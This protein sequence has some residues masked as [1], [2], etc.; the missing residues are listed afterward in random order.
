MTATILLSR[1]GAESRGARLE[2]GVL[3]DYRRSA[4]DAPSQ[5]GAVYAA[6]VRRMMPGFDAA[7]VELP[8]SDAWLDF[9]RRRE[10]KPAE[11]AAIVV[12]VVQDGAS[13]KLP[14]VSHE[15]RLAGRFLLF[16][17]GSAR[18]G[19][20]HRIM[21]NDARARLG[22]LVARLSREG[23]GGFLALHRAEHA[24]DEQVRGEA[25]HLRRSW[26]A[27]ARRLADLKAPAEAV[28]PT[29]VALDL[30][31]LFVDPDMA[32]IIVDSENL[33]REVR[34]WLALHAA[35]WRGSVERKKVGESGLAAFTICDQ[36][37]QS[38][39]TEVPLPSGG[40]LLIETTAALT[41]ID[42]DSAVM[43][44]A[45]SSA[46][47]FGRLKAEAVDLAARQIR[48]RNLGGR[49]VIDF[50]GLGA[51]RGLERL[52]ANLRAAV[53]DDPVSVRVARPTE[54]GLVELVRRRERLPL[55][56]MLARQG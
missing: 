51:A 23:E 3:T 55:A 39:V 33:A 4:P 19:L 34:E 54:L 31:R 44:G 22:D 15:P 18:G 5:V 2:N 30:L 40:R 45:M 1:T 49:I 17:P 46:T 8:A 12:Q 14:R 52:V 6:R 24:G 20:S 26:E 53:A 13:G 37:E 21:G 48:L 10:R 42:V 56:G 29:D 43:P 47:S 35:E 9:S 7:I 41:A 36:L 32:Q 27:A 11:G 50:A 38:L 28:P 16:M 25:A